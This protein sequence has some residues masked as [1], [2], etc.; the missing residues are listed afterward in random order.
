M[1]LEHFGTPVEMVDPDIA[2]DCEACGSEM[3]RYEKT[4]CKTCGLNIHTGCVKTC[5]CGHQGC[6]D[7]MIKDEDTGEYTCDTEECK[8][9]LN[10]IP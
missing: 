8:T 1:I 3:Y 4:E 6:S 5:P 9:K 10:L 2:G 7:C